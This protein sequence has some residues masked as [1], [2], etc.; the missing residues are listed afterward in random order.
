MEG[1]FGVFMRQVFLQTP[2]IHDEEPAEIKAVFYKY[3]TLERLKR[4]SDVL[5]GGNN[6]RFYYLKKGLGAFSFEDKHRRRV[7]FNLVLPGRV[8]ADVDGISKEVV[9]VVDSVIRPSEVMSISYETW[10]QH[11]GS[12]PALMLL[13]MKGIISKHESH[14]EAMI[15]NYT[16]TVEERLK[17][18]IKVLFNAYKIN[19][20]EGWHKIPLVLTVSEYASLV[21][22]SRISVSRLF[23][24]WISNGLLTKHKRDFSVKADLFHDV[25]DW[26]DKN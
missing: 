7:I 25:Y 18:F 21:G 22:A 19:I 1:F 6:G 10:L 8:F 15:A 5:N 23:G 4:G 17:V 9:N 24:S 12:N 16:L 20:S 11:I 26:L 14:M 13:T 2:W 3:G